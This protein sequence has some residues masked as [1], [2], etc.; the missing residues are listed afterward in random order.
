MNI[1]IFDVISIQ[2]TKKSTFIFRGNRPKRGWRIRLFPELNSVHSK[3]L[4]F[5][6]AFRSETVR[7]TPYPIAVSNKRAIPPLIN[8]VGVCRYQLFK[9]S[10]TGR[11]Q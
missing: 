9:L 11:F 10:F 2:T 4:H 3:R 1:G 8:V 7:N 5:S 6:G